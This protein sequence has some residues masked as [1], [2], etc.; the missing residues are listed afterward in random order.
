VRSLSVLLFSV[1]AAA[2]VHAMTFDGRY[3]RFFRIDQI[4]ALLKMRTVKRTRSFDFFGLAPGKGV[5]VTMLDFRVR[6][7]AKVNVGAA[8]CLFF[9]FSAR[10]NSI[11]SFAPQTEL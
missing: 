1:V 3:R 5:L 7:I 11:G 2:T 8:G 4:R 9:E 10:W 6:H